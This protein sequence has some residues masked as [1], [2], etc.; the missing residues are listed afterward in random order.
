MSHIVLG[1]WNGSLS[2]VVVCIFA[3]N[4]WH[5]ECSLLVVVVV[6]LLVF[7]KAQETESSQEKWRNAESD[8]VLLAIPV[9]PI[10]D[11]LNTEC[12][13]KYIFVVVVSV[14]VIVSTAVF[15]D[16]VQIVP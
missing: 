16:I 12:I 1:V 8:F 15:K 13:I 9:P 11:F 5:T 14:D 4:M 2:V 10:R 7:G 3:T 6:V